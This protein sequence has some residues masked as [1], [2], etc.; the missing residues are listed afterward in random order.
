MRGHTVKSKS[1]ST[2]LVSPPPESRSPIRNSARAVARSSPR[3]HERFQCHRKHMV[4]K[5][6]AKIIVVVFGFSQSVSK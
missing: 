6:P 3:Q 2:S 4:E 5:I 1:V